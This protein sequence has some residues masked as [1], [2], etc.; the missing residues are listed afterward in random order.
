MTLKLFVRF[1]DH[2]RINPWHEANS[3]N[4]KVQIIEAN[5]AVPLSLW[6]PVPLL[7]GVLLMASCQQR[8]M[9]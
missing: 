1:V 6:D 3:S 9:H 4:P 8:S 2:G 7:C 5:V